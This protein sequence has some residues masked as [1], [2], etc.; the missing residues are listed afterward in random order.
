MKKLYTVAV[1]GATGLV[2][3]TM[4]TVLEELNFPVE[5]LVPLASARSAGMEVPFQGKSVKV[6]TLTSESFSG[7]DFAL[8]S[9]G[10]SVSKEFGPIAAQ[11]GAVVIDNSSAFRMDADVPLVVPEVNPKDAF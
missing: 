11:Q 9:A 3:R 10:A 7:V 2:G 5:R 4:I 8:F 1:A 6:Q